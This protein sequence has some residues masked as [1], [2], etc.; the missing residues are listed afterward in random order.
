MGSLK[1]AAILL[2]AGSP[3]LAQ[4]SATYGLGRVPT[5]EELRVLDITI[6][7]SGEGLPEGH[8]TPREGAKVFVDQGCVTCHGEDG[9]G[10]LAPVLK[11][12]T[13]QDSPMWK[14]ERILPLRAP[15]A[16]IVWDFIRRGMP[17]GREGTLT[18]DE[19]Y[20]VTAYLLFLNKVIP[21]DAV[22]DKTSLPKVKMP[23]GD[24]YARLP[25]WKHGA[26]RL[27][28]YPY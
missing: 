10:A 19:V 11:S 2:L 1:F 28:G 17:V 25:D 7:P 12:K 9:V 20:A 18:P 4:S 5:A 26:P 8:G 14:R 15:H 22:L 6:S 23:I 27:E 13:S 16:T 24:G 3:A 21:E